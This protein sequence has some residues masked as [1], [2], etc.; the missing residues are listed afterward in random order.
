MKT[1]TIFIIVA[2]VI[3]FILI[4]SAFTGG[5]LIGQAF[6]LAGSP[7]G[8]LIPG[9]SEV[10]ENLQT[11]L[12]STSNSQKIDQLFRP[13]WQAWEL[14]NDKYVEQPVDQTALMRGAIK[15][16]LDA[17]GDDHTSYLDPDMMKRFEA[18]L[19]G[20]AYEGIGATV[21]I[22]AEY[23]T[24]ISPFPGS[25]AEKAGLLSGDEIIAV[26]GKDVTG[27]DPELVLKSVKGPKDTKVI[28]TI[29]REGVEQPFDVEIVRASIIVPTI[30]AKML[31]DNI[32]YVHLYSF[33]DKTGQDLRNSLET[34][35]AENPAGLI[36][37]LRYN[38]GGYLDTSIEVAS[39]FL[40]EGVIVYEEYGN[41]QRE[42]FEATQDGMATNIPLVVLVNE[43]S[44]SASEI[45]AGAIQD[46]GRGELVGVTTYG[47]GS[48][49]TVVSL[50]DEQGQVRVTIARWLTP[51][52]RQ[53][54][55]IGLE[56]DHVVEITQEDMEAGRDPQ[57]EK[58]IELLLN[59]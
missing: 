3:G 5:F 14:V 41:G 26:D 55:K 45:V 37:D 11:P 2:L 32:A 56:P 24:I 34:L 29:R 4:T 33:G 50:V 7:T 22:Q 15:G 19:N 27:I 28:L 36:L 39:Q 54:N 23:L 49:Q 38:S 31:E 52:E 35:L 42:A 59:K 18:A 21:D 53:I 12:S 10:A 44:A 57:L 46:Y 25:P 9:L 17:V 43:G 58:A 6:N 48:V 51:K 13:F 30:E 1:K 40:D 16:M 8:K 47:K 20:E